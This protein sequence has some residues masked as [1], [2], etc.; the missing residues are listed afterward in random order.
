MERKQCFIPGLQ[1]G[2]KRDKYEQLNQEEVKTPSFSV[3]YKNS[4]ILDRYEELRQ[5]GN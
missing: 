5:E 1:N 2:E 3:G 4:A